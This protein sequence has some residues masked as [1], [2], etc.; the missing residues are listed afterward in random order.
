MQDLR[1]V[2]QF[3]RINRTKK[4]TRE[5]LHKMSCPACR[6]EAPAPVMALLQ[7]L[8]L[9]PVERDTQTDEDSGERKH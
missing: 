1:T 5:A 6:G 9:V 8:G 3:N 2:L 7:S 4:R